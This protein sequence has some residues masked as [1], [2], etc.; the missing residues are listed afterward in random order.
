MSR[1]SEVKTVSNVAVNLESRS[2]RR[3]RNVV[4]RP[5]RSIRSLLVLRITSNSCVCSLSQ[6]LLSI[7]GLHHFTPVL[8]G[9]VRSS[10]YEQHTCAG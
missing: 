8:H 7:T 5:P 6:H 10:H 9:A 2:R 3:K 4:I 1:P